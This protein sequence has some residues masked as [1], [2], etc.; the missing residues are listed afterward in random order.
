MHW[1]PFEA[2]W[3]DELLAAI[4]PPGRASGGYASVDS[5]AFWARLGATAPPLLALGLRASVWAMTL[6]PPLI[7]GVARTFGGLAPE[8]RQRYLEALDQHPV[9]AVRQLPMLLKTMGCF[10]YF[11]DESS[12]RRAESAP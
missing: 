10:A 3:R 11:G 6:G 9:A 5:E 8:D 1:L 12:R 2:R 7:I 4:V